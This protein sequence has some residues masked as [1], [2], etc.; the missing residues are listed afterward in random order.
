M[1]RPSKS[2]D[3]G[4][5]AEKMEAHE[6]AKPLSAPHFSRNRNSWLKSKLDGKDTP[7]REMQ[8]SLGLKSLS[9]PVPTAKPL[10]TVRQY[11]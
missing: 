7:I 10:L 11:R 4:E 1:E 3:H 6:W 2:F 5:T 9:V 8:F